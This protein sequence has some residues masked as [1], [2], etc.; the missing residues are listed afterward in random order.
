MS[1]NK[2]NKIKLALTGPPP[3]PKLFN[4]LQLAYG[5]CGSWERIIVVGSSSN[6]GRYQHLGA[7]STLGIA[8]DATPQR[9]TELLNISASC[10]KDVVIFSSLSDEWQY[11]VSHH[12]N[13]SYYEDVLKSHRML[14]HVMRHAPV[15]VIA[16]IE[17]RNVFLQKDEKGKRRLS[18]EQIIQ[19]PGIEKQFTTVLRMDKRGYAGVAK[20]G[21]KVFDVEQRFKISLHHGARLHDWCRGGDPVISLELQHR[22]DCCSTLSELYQL[23]FELDADDLDVLSAFTRKRLEMDEESKEQPLEMIPGGYL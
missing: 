12:L 3:A 9:Y 14:F 4:A 5:L 13:T 6:D 23:L 8:K 18:T 10:G 1:T 2:S 17:T 20:D 16:C 19:Q 22:I 21:A 15:H 7:Y 11:G